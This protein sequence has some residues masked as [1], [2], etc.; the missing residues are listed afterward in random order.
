M[1]V[2]STLNGCDVGATRLE[3]A[4]L[5]LRAGATRRISGQIPGDAK[6]VTVVVDARSP[7]RRDRRIARALI[8]ADAW[9]A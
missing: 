9:C 5:L 8:V 2:G 1:T 7:S 3:F 6:L 4:G